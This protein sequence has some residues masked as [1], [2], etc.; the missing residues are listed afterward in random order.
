MFSSLLFSRTLIGLE[1]VAFDCNPR[2]KI[3]LKLIVVSYNHC[4]ETSCIFELSGV[5]QLLRPRSPTAA[6]CCRCRI[7]W[8]LESD[9]GRRRIRRNRISDEKRTP[10]DRGRI[11]CPQI[12]QSSGLLGQ[13]QRCLKW[14][15]RLGVVHIWR[16]GFRGWGSTNIFNSKIAAHLDLFPN[17]KV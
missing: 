6:G 9:G 10:R 3:G 14:R 5:H 16:H 15:F 13:S 11:K 2:Q 8:V 4:S 1:N 7:R 17:I 12:H